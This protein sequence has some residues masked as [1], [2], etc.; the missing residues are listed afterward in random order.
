VRPA[1]TRAAHT[2]RAVRTQY[3]SGRQT[4]GERRPSR[5]PPLAPSPPAVRPRRYA[6][7]LDPATGKS[8]LV[9]GNMDASTAKEAAWEA[10]LKAMQEGA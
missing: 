7:L 4:M 1:D 5:L 6:S 2:P 9:Y 10:G 8:G 3:T